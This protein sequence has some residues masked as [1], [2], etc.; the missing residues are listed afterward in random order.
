MRLQ[1]LA[2][3]N[4]RIVYSECCR[5]LLSLTYKSLTCADPCLCLPRICVWASRRPDFSRLQ[6]ERPSEPS[7]GACP[8]SSLIIFVGRH[9]FFFMLRCGTELLCRSFECLPFWLKKITYCQVF[10][11][12]Q[13]MGLTSDYSCFVASLRRVA[14]QVLKQSYD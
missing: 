10:L 4:A 5:Y 1:H 12:H 2:S 11:L 7:S 3:S 14:L 13:G 6:S 9:L 8:R